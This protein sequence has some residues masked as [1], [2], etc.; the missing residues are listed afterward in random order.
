MYKNLNVFQ[1]VMKQMF[2]EDQI[3]PYT[4]KWVRFRLEAC[5]TDDKAL[6]CANMLQRFSGV[7]PEQLNITMFPVILGHSPAGI[8]FNQVR[9]YSQLAKSSTFV[10]YDHG[11]VI[12]KK[13][14]GTNKPP[15]YILENIS[16]PILL[17]Y[18]QND[19]LV[20][21]SD[22]RLLEKQLSSV[23][24]K[25]MV[26]N[27]DFSHTDYMWAIQGPEFVYKPMS[28]RMAQVNMENQ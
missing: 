20:E 26:K 18:S 7:D 27:K 13:L 14:Y 2:G 15:K 6:V 23:R 12:N 8:S 10:Q 3:C 1:A 19:L 16:A 5:N 28:E 9:H 4:E 17:I 21:P 11:P 22:V 25:Y 24:E